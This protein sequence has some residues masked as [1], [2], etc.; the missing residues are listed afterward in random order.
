M[1]LGQ[2]VRRGVSRL[3]S[4]AASF[5]IVFVV[6]TGAQAQNKL[7]DEAVEFTGALLFLETKVPA[8]VL[9]VV[10]GG[11]TAVAGFGKARP[12]ADGPPDRNTLL[13]IGSITKVF[14]GAVLAS[15]VADRVVNFTDPLQQRLGWDVK[16]PSK[17]GKH[18]RLIDLVTHASGLPREI[19]RAPS[20]A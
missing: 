19:E 5:A 10:R 15:L 18:I 4:A 17:E 16:I 20:P 2:L 8:L 7:L 3:G 9:G 14:T 1:G 13:R 6:A 11:E 12:D